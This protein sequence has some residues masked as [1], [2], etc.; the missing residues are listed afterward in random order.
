MTHK[1]FSDPKTLDI[2]DRHYLQ[3]VARQDH[4]REVMERLATMPQTLMKL[5]R[6]SV[7][8]F[9]EILKRY[10][11]RDTIEKVARQF[12]AVGVDDYVLF[13]PLIDEGAVD[14]FW[15]ALHAYAE[16]T[17][18]AD[19]LRGR[20]IDD[21]PLDLWAHGRYDVAAGETE[22]PAPDFVAHVLTLEEAYRAYRVM[23]AYHKGA[24][25]RNFDTYVKHRVAD[26]VV[27]R[28]NPTG[29]VWA[30]E[31]YKGLNANGSIWAVQ[32]YKRGETT[33]Q[34]APSYT[35]ALDEARNEQWLA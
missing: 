17:A 2:E 33:L 30:A 23:V 3:C 5:Q 12:M 24:A 31:E 8:V 29:S 16:A 7:E 9:A 1:R 4:A 10:E 11:Q 19:A 18:T 26:R 15:C 27:A 32:K 35:S 34:H 14:L 28:L 20:R 25:D 21:L 13:H 22:P 6:R